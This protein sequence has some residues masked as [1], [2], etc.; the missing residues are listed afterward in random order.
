MD[1]IKAL[2]FDKDG[3]L[4]DTAL[5]WKNF[6]TGVAKDILKLWKREDDTSLFLKLM[7]HVGFN[8]NGSIIPESIVVSGTSVDII[9]G[10]VKIFAESGISVTKEELSL[11]FEK[12]YRYGKVEP[13]YSG[14]KEIFEY[15]FNREIK[16]ALATSDNY[17]SSLHCCKLL[18]IDSFIS[19][20]AS[21]DK[22]KRPKPYPDSMEYITN[23]LGIAPENIVMIGDSAN[24]M[25]FAKNSGAKAV[26]LNSHSPTPETADIHIKDIKEMKLWI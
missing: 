24:D 26:F 5:F 2:V 3:T 22:V 18:G 8:E 10:W 23:L 25:L 15:Y 7:H 16:I 11:R 12:D 9:N 4:I 6:S 14:I 21:K 17:D 1:N 20:I 19:V 13:L